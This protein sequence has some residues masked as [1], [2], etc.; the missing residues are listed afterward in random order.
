TD[1][2]HFSLTAQLVSGPKHGSVTLN[3]D[4][5]FTFVP[6]AGYTGT[7]SFTYQASNGYGLSA[8]TTVTLNL[9]PAGHGA[10]SRRTTCP[11]LLR[12]PAAA[13]VFA[14]IRPSFRISPRLGSSLYC[15]AKKPSRLLVVHQHAPK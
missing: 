11:A 8:V 7:D 9:T 4:G 14:S 12:S 6:K 5:S 13:A 2:K 1:P 10:P 15:A 3:A